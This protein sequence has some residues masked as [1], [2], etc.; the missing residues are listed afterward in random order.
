[1]LLSAVAGGTGA[2]VAGPPAGTPLRA[3][4]T[5]SAVQ[6]SFDLF[7]DRLAADWMRAN[8]AAATSQ[9][10]FSG[11]EQ[12]ALDRDLTAQD[13]QYGMPLGSAELSAYVARARAGLQ[14]VRGFRRDALT[15]VQRVSAA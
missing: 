2:L 13:A 9:Q 11:T 7:V 4:P 12:D 15:A 10:Y 5:A 6:A 1:M 8:P 14:G 3:A